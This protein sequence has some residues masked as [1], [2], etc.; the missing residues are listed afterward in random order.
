[1]SS[2]AQGLTRA[3]WSPATSTNSQGCTTWSG[4][5]VASCVDCGTQICGCGNGASK[6]LE[7]QECFQGRHL[8]LRWRSRLQQ[9]RAARADPRA[10]F[11]ISDVVRQHLFQQAILVLPRVFGYRQRAALPACASFPALSIPAASYAFLN[12]LQ[13]ESASGIWNGF[14]QPSQRP[15][16]LGRK[17]L[18]K[19]SGRLARWCTAESLE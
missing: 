2:L 16:L 6:R 19:L 14:W 15:E 8:L 5:I 4:R 12:A 3:N 17:F 7:L 18:P 10:V 11:E 13:N 9:H 1:M